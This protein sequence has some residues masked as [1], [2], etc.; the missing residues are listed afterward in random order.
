MQNRNLSLV[1]LIVVAETISTSPVAP[2]TS[3][4]SSHEGSLEVE[5]T[6]GNLISS[7]SYVSRLDDKFKRIGDRNAD[8]FQASYVKM[9]KQLQEQF[10]DL[11]MRQ[12]VSEKDHLLMEKW[13]VDNIN[14]LHRELK[15]TESEFEHYIQVTKNIMTQNERR[16]KQQVAE[17]MSLPLHIPIPTVTSQLRPNQNVGEFQVNHRY[18]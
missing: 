15:Q 1:L 3:D 16:L 17:A 9:L 13:L 7:P 6:L 12:R 11:V 14:D 5:N 2:R 10:I 4:V 8:Q 18:F